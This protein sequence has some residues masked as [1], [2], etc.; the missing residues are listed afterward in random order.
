[1]SSHVKCTV[2]SILLTLLTT[3]VKRIVLDWII[4][5]RF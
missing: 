2:T 4:Y 5:F 3:G 1:V